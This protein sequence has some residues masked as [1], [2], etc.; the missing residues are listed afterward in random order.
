M[1][2]VVAGGHEGAA[3]PERASGLMKPCIDAKAEADRRLEASG[4][5]YTIVRPGGLTD[6]TP[7]EEALRSR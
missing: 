5:A 1:D 6:D 4:L 2:V 7:I 3:H